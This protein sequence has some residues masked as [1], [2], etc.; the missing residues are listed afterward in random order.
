MCMYTQTAT[1]TRQQLHK[2]STV[3]K[4]APCAKTGAPPAN[5][6][7]KP[8]AE[9]KEGSFSNINNPKMQFCKHARTKSRTVISVLRNSHHLRQQALICRRA[10]V[11]VRVWKAS[12]ALGGERRRP[13]EGEKAA[14]TAADPARHS[15]SGGRRGGDGARWISHLRS[16]WWRRA[17]ACTSAVKKT[18]V[19]LRLTGAR[20]HPAH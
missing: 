20:R 3:S 4:T 11:C 16:G 7:E 15:T 10:C 8:P 2:C 18:P 1:L 6:R 19:W 5:G 14:E 9:S 12:V 13:E 17:R